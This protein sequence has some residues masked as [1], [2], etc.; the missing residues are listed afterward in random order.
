MKKTLLLTLS[1]GLAGATSVMADADLFITG[2]TAFRSQVYNACQKM[3]SGTPTIFTGT[4]A[5]GGDTKTGSSAAQWTMTG[6][7]SAALTQISGTLTIHGLFTGSVQGCQ[8]VENTVKLLFM[9]KTGNKMTN[10]P[11]IAFSDV[12]STSTPYPATGNYSEEQV[13][14]Q[15]FVMCHSVPLT[16]ISNISYEQLKYTIQAG[17]IPLS[18]W[19]NK[20]TDHGT[21]IYLLNRTL[22]SGTRRTTFAMENNGFNVNAITYNYDPTN[23]AFYKATNTLNAATGGVSNNVASYGVVGTPGNNGAN[24]QWGQGY[25]GGGD[26]KTALGYSGSSFSADQAIAYLS[27]AD[28]QGVTGVNWS[29]VMSI[30]GMWPTAAGAGITAGTGTTNDFSPIVMGMYPHWATEV[31]IYPIVDPN[32]IS[33]DQDLTAAQLGDQSSP[34]TLL[35]VLDYQTKFSNPGGPTIA[36]S[37][38]NEIQLSKSVSPGAT[39]IRL[40]DMTSVRASVGGT[41]TP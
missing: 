37:L 3:F 16:S 22:D 41:I 20:S 14:V 17:R 15:P 18:A 19:S 31:V 24:L 7:P 25:V 6:T 26:I 39:A 8:T 33:T 29:Q 13:A 21:F 2:S 28:A 23:N 35:G 27:L 40:S 36:G 10:T 32:S 1:F 9:D 11:T 12:S 38:E 30:N 5:T 4:P 34:G